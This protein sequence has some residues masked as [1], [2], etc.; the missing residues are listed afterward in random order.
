MAVVLNSIMQFAFMVAVMFCIGDA[1]QVTNTP[2]LLPIIEVYYQ[3]TKSKPATNIL[4]VMIAFILF[5]S[6]FNIF[7]SVSRLTWAFARDNGL[8]FSKTF[9]YVHPTLKI[10][11]NSLLLVGLI[12]C[13]LAIINIAS[14]TAFYALISLPTIALY[15]SYFIPILFLVIRKLQNRH[16]AYGPFKL[17]RWGLPIN[18]FSLVYIIY[19]IVFLPFPSM[20][21]VTALNMNYAGPLVGAVILMALG[22]WFISGRKR[23]SVPI[24][25][26]TKCDE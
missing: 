4:V 7:A 6:L 11:I 17:G 24:A 25:R 16:P 15:I 2:T 8:P 5:I 1:D 13:L 18:L 10:P 14:S 19:I 23:F 22:D 26:A 9:S 20:R 21:P 3:A 12:C